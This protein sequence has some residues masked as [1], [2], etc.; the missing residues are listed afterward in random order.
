M[1]GLEK[2]VFLNH[3][4]FPRFM[5]IVA[6]CY[7]IYWSLV[8]INFGLIKRRVERC[9]KRQACRR[10]KKNIFLLQVNIARLRLSHPS[11]VIKLFRVVESPMRHHDYCR[12]SRLPIPFPIWL[13]RWIPN[14]PVRETSVA[15]SRNILRT[16]KESF[17]FYIIGNVLFLEPIR[18][19]NKSYPKVI[20]Y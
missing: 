18:H 7:R 13:V 17:V 5:P 12:I 4:H 19:G 2:L 14:C 15:S 11:L 3:L 10:I 16:P 9:P 8:N 20:L 6:F 1:L